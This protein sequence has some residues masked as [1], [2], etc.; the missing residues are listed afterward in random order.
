MEEDSTSDPSPLLIV[1]NKE[2]RDILEYQ[3]ALWVDVPK[4]KVDFFLA[5]WLTA[6][7]DHRMHELMNTAKGIFRLSHRVSEISVSDLGG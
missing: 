4:G 1:W 7:G 3:K 5:T 6:A 2:S